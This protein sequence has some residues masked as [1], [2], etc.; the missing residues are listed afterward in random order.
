MC[1]PRVLEQDR[2]ETLTQAPQWTE[3][4]LRIVDRHARRV[5]S[6]R[7][8]HAKA[9]VPRCRAE[10]KRFCD[11]TPGA[12]HHALLLRARMLG[13]PRILV[14]WTTAEKNLLDRFAQAVADGRIETAREAGRQCQEATRRLHRRWPARYAGV[15][16]RSVYTIQHEIWPRVAR[17]GLRWFN[18]HWSS[19]ERG[20]V[21]RYARLAI[22]HRYP[23]TRAAARACCKAIN[24]LHDSQDRRRT[25]RCRP[26]L[27]RT[28]GAVYDQVFDRTRE[29][30]PHRLPHR[31]WTAAEI[32]VAKRWARKYARHLRGRLRMNRSTM[33]Q[34]MQAELD[35]KGY[36][37]T[38]PA[39]AHEIIRRYR[40]MTAPRGQPQP[41]AHR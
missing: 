27:V 11:R 12:V 28:L 33:A 25:G 32:R 18:S 26:V 1:A 7:Y 20:L 9:A 40:L 17:L 6:G 8:S 3:Q 24:R 29:L 21:D 22:A 19:Q 5:V 35:R 16:D 30:A 13:R 4:E 39:C 36:Y 38:V 41:T 10:L 23:D 31:R 14:R 37:R 34:L 2:S 15:P